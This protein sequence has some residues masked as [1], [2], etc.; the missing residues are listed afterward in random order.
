MRERYHGFVRYCAFLL[1]ASFVACG[2]SE[3]KKVTQPVITIAAA[4][5]LREVLEETRASATAELGGTE[6]RFSFDASSSLARQIEASD[7]YDV[8]LSADVDTVER[9]RARLDG[10][11]IEPF[12]GND[13]VMV[14]SE[15]APPGIR[16]PSRLAEVSGR[17]AL[18]GEAVPAGKYARALLRKIGLL[19]A[20]APRI[21]SSDNV[22]S[23]LA[24]VESGAAEFGFVYATDARIAK[25]A[26]SVWT[27]PPELDPGVVYVAAVVNGAPQPAHVF[28]RWLRGEEF[29]IAATQRGFKPLSL[30]LS[31]R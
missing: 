8:F 2:R 30:S 15:H 31:G 12:L 17:I 4:S 9:I 19:D 3:L 21:V 25:K 13:L 14:V 7:G 24:M 23:T 16:E 20:L 1:A 6:V 27:A 26:R 29:R 11:T 28:V 18:A 5:S 22:R 10:S